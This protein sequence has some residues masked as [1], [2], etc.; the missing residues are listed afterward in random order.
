MPDLRR[1]ASPLSAVTQR[2]VP[3]RVLAF[4]LASDKRYAAQMCRIFDVCS[5]QSGWAGSMT[6]VHPGK[7]EFVAWTHR[8]VIYSRCQDS[9][10]NPMEP[11]SSAMQKLSSMQ[12]TAVEPS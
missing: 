10:R 9:I 1:I 8:R 4:A 3:P 2:T 6:T 12:G 5:A 7:R 11:D